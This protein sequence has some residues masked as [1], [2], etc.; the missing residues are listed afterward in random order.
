MYI[1]SIDIGFEHFGMIGAEVSET[2]QL[3]NVT[4][5]KLINIKNTMLECSHENCEL[6]HTM[7]ISDYMAHLFQEYNDVFEKSHII[8]IERQ[9]PKGF[10]AIQELILFKY[11]EKSLLLSPN[12]IH[13]HFSMSKIQKFRK[14]FTEK[15]SKERLQPF[16][17]YTGN[18]R[19]H[20]M[21]DAYCQL[22]Y[23]LNI[24][25]SR[26]N[27]PPSTPHQPVT[28]VPTEK[29][30]SKYFQTHN[31]VTKDSENQFH[32]FAYSQSVSND[33]KQPQLTKTFP[34]M[35]HTKFGLNCLCNFAKNY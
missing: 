1:L 17:D 26:K 18:E 33:P 9:P 8:L 16:P 27:S 6:K 7:C 4:F 24:E 31:T 28:P 13:K 5:C 19:K 12:A 21:G 34:L 30:V 3:E 35:K 14:M 11:R 20:D 10:V 2:Y 29:N 23:Y 15:L 32:K 22:L 25:H